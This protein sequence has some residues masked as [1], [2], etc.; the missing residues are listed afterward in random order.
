[1]KKGVLIALGIAVLIGAIVWSKYYAEAQ[2]ETALN[3]TFDSTFSKE[4]TE[5]GETTVKHEESF[6]YE[7]PS[8]ES[9]ETIVKSKEYKNEEFD[10]VIS[11]AMKDGKSH[12]TYSFISH[13]PRQPNSEF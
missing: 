7:E 1:M 13:G 2:K 8:T 11:T 5:A 9:E 3:N 4:S 6:E 10:L 12:I